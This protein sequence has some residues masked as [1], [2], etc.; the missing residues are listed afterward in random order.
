[1]RRA[2]TALDHL[3]AMS[4][5]SSD[6][7]G[8]KQPAAVKAHGAKTYRIILR[9]EERIA[10]TVTTATFDV[11]DLRGAWSLPEN[12]NQHYKAILD[13]FHLSCYNATP[14]IIEIQASGF[15]MQS[16]SFDTGTSATTELLGVASGA[17]N[18]SI[19]VHDTFMTLRSLPSGRITI[20]L[21]SRD[22]G[23]LQ[24]PLNAD[25]TLR[26]VAVIAIVQVSE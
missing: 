23:D 24:T 10:G 19:D 3:S 4:D 9:S 17:V 2:L 21:V 5:R 1:M 11:G 14:S 16:E 20:K 8:F 6:D 18:V 26:W 13:S 7:P 25:N 22:A 12:V 15:L